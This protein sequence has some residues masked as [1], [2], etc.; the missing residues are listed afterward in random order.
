MERHGSH[1]RGRKTVARTG[2]HKDVVAEV[3]A[4]RRRE[5]TKSSCG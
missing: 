2:N 4:I 1:K 3:S 5:E